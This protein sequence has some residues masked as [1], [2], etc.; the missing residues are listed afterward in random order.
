MD[1][2]S[3]NFG[4]IWLNRTQRAQR[5]RPRA[6]QGS[7]LSYP[8]S[9]GTHEAS[10]IAT[11]ITDS[12]SLTDIETTGDD[13]ADA[14]C[15]SDGCCEDTCALA[16]GDGG[17]ASDDGVHAG[18][19]SDGCCED[20]CAQAFGDGGAASDTTIE[21]ATCASATG[22]EGCELWT[23]D[24]DNA[25]VPGGESGFLDARNAQ[26]AVGIV[27]SGRRCQGHRAGTSGGRSG[28]GQRC[29]GHRAAAPFQYP[30]VARSEMFVATTRASGRVK[31]QP[32]TLLG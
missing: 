1:C 3:P 8:S 27:N 16:F 23:V 6:E 24:L 30:Q 18:C 20:T 25:F 17:D 28:A 29:Q 21:P 12:T 14:G 31:H 10:A 15:P 4:R 13:G 7:R 22:S 5:P 19:P 26:F 32:G 2:K 11:S 9:G